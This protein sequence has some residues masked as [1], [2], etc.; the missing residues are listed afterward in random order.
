MTDKQVREFVDGCTLAKSANGLADLVDY[1]SYELYLDPLRA[2]LFKETGK[3]LRLI[4]KEDRQVDQVVMLGVDQ[5]CLANLEK[6]G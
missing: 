2:G 3:H 5:D 4:V 1:P 6:P